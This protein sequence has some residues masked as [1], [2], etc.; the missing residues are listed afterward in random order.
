MKFANFPMSQMVQDAI[1]SKIGDFGD[2]DDFDTDGFSTSD[3]SF[4]ESIFWGG[5]YTDEKSLEIIPDGAGILTGNFTYDGKPAVGVH[6]YLVL[7]GMFKTDLISTDDKG[8][9]EIKLPPG[10][11]RIN[12]LKCRRW[13]NKPKGEFLLLSGDEPKFKEG[14]YGR[15][16]H[17]FGSDGKE[18]TVKESVTDTNTLNFT[19][20]KRIN[21]KFPVNFDRNQFAT[22]DDAIQWE[23]CKDAETYV[24]KINKLIKSGPRSTTIHPI[25]YR[26]VKD[27][28]PIRFKDLP[29]EK[30]K[31]AKE[32][33]S[34]SIRAYDEDGNL[35][36]ASNL[37]SGSFIFPDGYVLK[38]EPDAKNDAEGFDVEGMEEAYDK[39]KLMNAVE[40]MIQ[41]KM[42]DEAIKLL[43][44]IDDEDLKTEKELLTGYYYA[45]I[46]DCEQAGTH[47]DKAKDLGIACIPSKYKL[48]CE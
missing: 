25:M 43:G 42:L 13:N 15:L 45:S 26:V 3:A 1:E 9:F 16:F 18:V 36:S 34:V 44:T 32:K 46:G 30:N 29:H 37:A 33:Y 48:D 21:I 12:S 8:R 41:G 24:V 10:T 47:F 6:F 20:R 7:N 22:M 17:M 39:H 5:I 38:E 27:A 11:Y 28:E 40:F 19:L 14:A 35:V 23:P 31:K 4:W 2:V